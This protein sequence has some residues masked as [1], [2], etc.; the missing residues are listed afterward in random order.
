MSED[1]KGKAGDLRVWWIPQVP[2]K[3]F[4]APVD[5]PREG[6]KLLTVLA[7]Y[8]LFQFENK[9]KPDYFNAGGLQ[10][11]EE[12]GNGRM[13][14]CDWQNEDGDDIDYIEFEDLPKVWPLP[15][16]GHK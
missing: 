10:M 8:D 1:H 15:K 5:S 2:M 7:E 4:Y 13:E 14:W 11:Y 9:V 16:K 3:A 12:D 6:K